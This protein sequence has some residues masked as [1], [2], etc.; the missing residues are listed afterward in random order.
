MLCA[1]WEQMFRLAC[2]GCFFRIPP[3]VPQEIGAFW[4]PDQN[5]TP[6]ILT[7]SPPPLL[8]KKKPRAPQR[9]IKSKWVFFFNNSF[10]FQ[11]YA[12]CSVRANVPSRVCGMFLSHTS[13]RAV[14]FIVHLTP[15]D[16]AKSQHTP[17][18]RWCSEIVM[19]CL[20]TSS[21]NLTSF[22]WRKWLRNSN[23]NRVI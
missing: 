19:R 8:F 15:R 16:E 11:V 1:Q 3:A 10:P 9:G 12:L 22:K 17:N 18:T 21:N 6:F 7:A 4:P 2:A 23:I 5:K 13:C 14:I 20:E